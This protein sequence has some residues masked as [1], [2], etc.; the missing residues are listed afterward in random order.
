MRKRIIT[1]IEAVALV[2]VLALAG[3]AIVNLENGSWELTP[4]LSGSMRPGFSVGGLAIS[5]RVPVTM[6]ADRDVIVFQDPIK[7]TEQVVH[8][9][10]QLRAHNG[11][12]LIN[13]QGDANNVRDPWTMTIK[14]REAYMV[15]WSVPL[16]G[17]GAV[18]FQNDR[19]LLLCGGGI[20]LF[21]IA[22]SLMRGTRKKPLHVKR[23]SVLP[24]P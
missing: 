18:W 2:V 1:I 8:R 12:F 14:G 20:V 6:L 11:A 16:V 24:I 22:G 23:R 7:P 19:G 21:A 5:E 3:F 15:R 13:T 4:V 17:Y 9:I 10:V